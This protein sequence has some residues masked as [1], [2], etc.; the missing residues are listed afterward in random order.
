MYNGKSVVDGVAGFSIEPEDVEEADEEGGVVDLVSPSPGPSARSRQSKRATPA[1]SSLRNASAILKG[2]KKGVSFPAETARQKKRTATDISPCVNS[3]G[4]KKRVTREMQDMVDVVSARLSDNDD[5]EDDGVEDEVP[6]P[7]SARTAS[8]R[9]K[10]SSAKSASSAAAPS[11]RSTRSGRK[12]SKE[13]EASPV[14]TVSGRNTRSGRKPAKEADESPVAGRSGRSSQKSA[15][16]SQPRRGRSARKN[17]RPAESSRT[18]R[19]TTRSSQPVE[20]AENIPVMEFEDGDLDDDLVEDG[21]INIDDDDIEVVEESPR[22]RRS[23]QRSRASAAADAAD[24]AAEA[25]EEQP[26]AARRRGSQKSKPAASAASTASAATDASKPRRR[27]KHGKKEMPRELRHLN[28][29]ALAA[30]DDDD[31]GMVRR[32]KR[33]RFPTLRFWSNEKL[34][35]ERRKSQ[36]MPTIAQVVVALPEGEEGEGSLSSNA[37]WLARGQIPL[38]TAGEENSAPTESKG[39]GR[40]RRGRKRARA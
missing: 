29:N 40:G 22:A 37:S 13:T 19:R 39:K 8:G 18:S 25:E 12:A 17:A 16:A 3:G 11:G 31:E 28:V 24:A 26:T 34:V 2:S 32:S 4:S 38:Q 15:T 27:A 35:Y 33:Q 23:S 14:P 5:L 10:R 20:E 30:A 6:D 21:T 1:R 36:I 7:S 9:S